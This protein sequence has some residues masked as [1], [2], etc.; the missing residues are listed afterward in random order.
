[1]T[2][3]RLPWPLYHLHPRPFSRHFQFP[4]CLLPF[5]YSA[6]HLPAHRRQLPRHH[7]HHRRRRHRPVVPADV[8]ANVAY[9]VQLLPVVDVS[10]PRK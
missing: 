6:L 4:F 10:P 2:F 1:M 7:H 8:L 5:G 3:Y 9:D